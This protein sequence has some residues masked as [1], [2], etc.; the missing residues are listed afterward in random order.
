MSQGARHENVSKV[1]VKRLSLSTIYD[2]PYVTF[3]NLEQLQE[4]SAVGKYFWT[5]ENSLY[6][7]THAWYRLKYLVD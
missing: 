6:P 1:R 7:A 2:P 3:G 4:E 5:T